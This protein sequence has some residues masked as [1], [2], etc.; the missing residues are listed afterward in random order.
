MLLQVRAY[1]HI[2][3]SR[4]TV[5][6]SA[7]EDVTPLDLGDHWQE[8]PHLNNL[9]EYFEKLTEQLSISMPSKQLA[10]TQADLVYYAPHSV[11]ACLALSMGPALQSHVTNEA[12][13]ESW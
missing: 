4:Y 10:L 8:L 13:A 9:E 7:D 3:E 12:S 1:L 5:L 6:T 11:A 2:D